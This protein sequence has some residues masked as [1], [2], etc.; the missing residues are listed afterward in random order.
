MHRLL[1]ISS[2]RTPITERD[3][4]AILRVSRRNNAA[5]RITGLLVTGG[6]RFLQV[7]EGEADTVAR[8]YARIAA[9]P[10]HT[11]LV[12][13]ASADVAERM[14]ADWAMGHVAGDDGATVAR[15]TAPI[16]D[17]TLRAYFDGFTDLH[18]AA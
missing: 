17:P 14:F 12:K 3:V 16:T 2:S 15:L 11:G 7:L 10:R 18:A 8:T 6:R 4:D 1:Y 9:D 13:L 5:D